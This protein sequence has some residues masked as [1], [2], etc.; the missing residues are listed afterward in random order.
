[1]KMGNQLQNNIVYFWGVC[2]LKTLRDNNL[3][4]DKEYR[5]I[6]EINAN[7]YD[8]DLICV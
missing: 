8:A 3:I 6:C 2:I 4:T 5:R 1:M 7:H